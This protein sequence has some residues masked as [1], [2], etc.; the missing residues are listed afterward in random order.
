[1]LRPFTHRATV[2]PLNDDEGGETDEC[3]EAAARFA[4]AAQDDYGTS[5]RELSALVEG[6]SAP[7]PFKPTPPRH[8][9]AEFV[10]DWMRGT[11]L[12]HLVAEKAENPSAHT[13]EVYLERIGAIAIEGGRAIEV[14]NAIEGGHAIEVEYT[15]V[16]VEYTIVHARVTC[17]RLRGKEYASIRVALNH[18]VSEGE[19]WCEVCAPFGLS[20][21]THRWKPVQGA[22]IALYM[23]DS[24]E[25]AKSVYFARYQDGKR[26][27]GWIEVFKKPRYLHFDSIREARGEL[28]RRLYAIHPPFADMIMFRTKFAPSFIVTYTK[29]SIA[30]WEVRITTEEFRTLE[31]LSD[32]VLPFFVEST[33]IDSENY[34]PGRAQ[35]T[36]PLLHVLEHRRKTGAPW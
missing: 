34:V 15:T 26:A 22:S 20:Y 6:K 3:I 23:G 36:E 9:L 2:S 19:E 27:T 5:Q 10:R 8:A 11:C 29:M 28:Y 30:M 12:E 16:E 18:R 17:P 1:M 35:F 7:P 13:F 24:E 31:K 4:L 25:T 21:R 33:P 14:E 32:G